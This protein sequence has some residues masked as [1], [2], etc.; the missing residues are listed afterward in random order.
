MSDWQRQVIENASQAIDEHYVFPERGRALATHLR[1]WSK[2]V[3]DDPE[4]IQ[5][6]SERVTA[7]IQGHTPDRH[8][9][10][11]TVVV[12]PARKRP[13]TSSGIRRLEILDDHVGLLELH[14]FPTAAPPALDA[15]MTLLKGVAALIL[16]FRQHRGGDSDV[17]SYFLGYFYA[18]RTLISTFHKRH[19]D[20]ADQHWTS[21]I[22]TG[23]RFLN[24]RVAIL[25]SN[26]TGSAAE[27]FAYFMQQS[28][29]AEVLGE[30][31]AGAAHPGEFFEVGHGLRIFV[32]TGRPESALT[33]LNWE[34]TGV[35]P[36]QLVDPGYALNKAICRLQKQQ[37]T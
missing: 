31:T 18:Q 28:G 10:L 6:F 32:P 14:E 29:R 9:R 34:G 4:D 35:I 13:D 36:D 15:A 23:P 12:T 1:D 17:E 37:I 3:R 16:D 26:V 2:T 21:A 27:S 19:E 7:E 24:R 8:L 5:E 30:P 20:R 33:G 11:T 22:V 25:V